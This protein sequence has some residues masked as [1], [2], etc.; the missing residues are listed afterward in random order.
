[1]QANAIDRACARLDFFF[2]HTTKE[3]LVFVIA[4]R[5]DEAD[6]EQKIERVLA[7]LCFGDDRLNLLNRQLLKQRQRGHCHCRR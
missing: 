4:K 5:L 2:A 7:R 3:D 1:M 6:A